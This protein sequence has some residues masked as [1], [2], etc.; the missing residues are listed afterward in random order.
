MYT[1][2]IIPK[3]ISVLDKSI[4]LSE[5]E[6]VT[7]ISHANVVLKMLLNASWDFFDKFA[8]DTHVATPSK[9]RKATSVFIVV[10]TRTPNYNKSNYTET[11]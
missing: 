5:S 9:T 4:T 11:P 8:A 3:Q 1:R 2:I 7:S 10:G 6:T